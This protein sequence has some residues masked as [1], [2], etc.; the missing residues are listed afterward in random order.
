VRGSFSRRLRNKNTRNHNFF[1]GVMLLQGQG[2]PAQPAEGV[3]FLKMAADSGFL[4]AQVQ[5]A[6]AYFSGTGTA[7]N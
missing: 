3:R 7:Q 5:L 6:N 4:P 2:G 1:Y